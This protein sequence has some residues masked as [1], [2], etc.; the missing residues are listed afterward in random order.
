M[1]A[2]MGLLIALDLLPMI[3]SVDDK[4]TPNNL[5][6]VAAKIRRHHGECCHQNSAL[7]KPR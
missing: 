3:L 1:T 7:A 5:P 4:S 2:L 6:G